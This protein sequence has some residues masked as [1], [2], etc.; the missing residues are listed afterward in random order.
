M[1][2]LPNNPKAGSVAWTCPS[3]IALIKYWGKRETQIPQ[4]PSLSMTLEKARTHTQI[5]F[6]YDPGKKAD[7]L[8]FRFEGKEAP[9]F[10]TRIHTYL[11]GL[12]TRHPFLKHCSLEIDSE[13]TFPH[14]S[15]IASSA[16]AMGALA[17]CLVQMEDQITGQALA[18]KFIQNAS[19][20]ARLGSGS[21][22]RSLFPGFSLWGKSDD[23]EGSSDEY[24]IPI[25]GYHKNFRKLRDAILIVESGQKPISSSTGH[26]LMN[27]NPFARKRF[28]QAHANL[29]LLQSVLHEGDWEGFISVVEEEALSLHAMMMTSKP[30]YILM[31]PETLSILHKI[32]AYRKETGHRLCF[33]LDAGA[34]VHLLY[35]DADANPVER[36]V[37]AELIRFCEKK[38]VIW[39]S[40]GQGPYQSEGS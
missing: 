5:R 14:S 4:N 1:Q 6:N 23:W 30:G 3:N 19:F 33:T 29:T 17:L 10:E 34:N 8:I 35:A 16:S 9:A 7:V 15:G 32:R 12:E 36:F 31:Q 26:G 25:P 2:D 38:Q 24:A 20:L 40:M 11:Q 28:E 18:E 37:N 27:S 13:N 39:D 21:A 22:C